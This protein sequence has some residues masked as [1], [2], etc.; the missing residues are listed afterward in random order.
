MPWHLTGMVSTLGLKIEAGGMFASEDVG[1][2]NEAASQGKFTVLLDNYLVSQNEGKKASAYQEG[3]T[4][5]NKLAYDVFGIHYTTATSPMSVSGGK[6]NYKWW[7][8]HTQD[9]PKEY[10]GS[11]KNFRRGIKGWW[12]ITK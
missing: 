8:V 10:E 11:E 2:I 1:T 9:K 6:L 5:L 4:I 12:V 7:D 3:D